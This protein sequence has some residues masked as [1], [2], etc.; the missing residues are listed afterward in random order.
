[1]SQKSKKMLLDWAQFRFSVIGGL[2]ARP[3]GRGELQDELAALSGRKYLHPTQGTWVR[4][5]PS[6]I[7]RWYYQALHADNPIDALGR[8]MRSDTGRTRAMSP[9][10]LEALRIQY[11]DHPDWSYQLHGDNLAALVEMQPELGPKPSY[12]TV[13]RRMK[14][15]GWYR[16]SAPPRNP[17]PGQIRAAER[18]E[19]RE[20]RSYESAYVNGLWHLDFHEG[21]RRVVDAHGTWHTPHALCI[22]DDCSRL[23]CHVQW[24]LRQTADNLYHGTVQ[25]FHKRGLPRGLMGD[26]GAAMRAEEIQNGLRRIGVIWEAILPYSAYQNGK[27]ENWFAQLEGRLMAMLRRVDPLTLEFLNRAT[28]AWAEME[29]NRRRHDEINMSP[30]DKFLE[31]PDVSRPSPDTDALRLAFCVQDKRKQRRSDGTLT[32]KG[33]R[34]ELPNR[35]RHMERVSVRYQSWDLS[36]AFLVDPRTGDLIGRIYP[37]DKNK[38]ANAMRRVLTPSDSAMLPENPVASDPVPPLLNKLLADYAATGL[39]PAYIPKREQG[40]SA[41]GEKNDA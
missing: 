9:A 35:F 40:P 5:A 18:L 26:N 28:Q 19:H 3:P 33:V 2:L 12:A 10:L 31:G 17:T 24:Y 41:Q 16:Q 7:E 25:A 38:N 20:V 27:Q 22:L 8:K 4:F 13:V 36:Q 6:T 23:G 34:F 32:I 30:L 37:L 39:P 11:G 14:Q 29:Y 15:Q 21:R 1:M